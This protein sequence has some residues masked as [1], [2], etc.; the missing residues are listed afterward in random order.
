MRSLSIACLSLLGGLAAAG[1]GQ[2][3]LVSAPL[4]DATRQGRFL[5]VGLKQAHRVVSTSGRTGA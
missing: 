2:N 5:V 3:T 4:F 1:W